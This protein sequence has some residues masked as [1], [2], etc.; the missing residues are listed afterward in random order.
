[1]GEGSFI[2]VGYL[3]LIKDLG[4]KKGG[5]GQLDPISLSFH[6]TIQDPSVEDN[7]FSNGSFTWNNQ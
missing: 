1:M 2:L 4:K 6:E 3:N 7:D 5:V